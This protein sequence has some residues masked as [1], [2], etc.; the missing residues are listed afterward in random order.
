MSVAI[1]N[2]TTLFCMS[3]LLTHRDFNY[4]C[5]SRERDLLKRL[6]WRQTVS[7]ALEVC[8]FLTAERQRTVNI[9]LG[10]PTKIMVFQNLFSFSANSL[11]PVREPQRELEESTFIQN[12]SCVFGFYSR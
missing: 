7:V 5:M 9:C 8:H 4:V 11:P 1:L 12:F 10:C 2:E 6:F 3:Y